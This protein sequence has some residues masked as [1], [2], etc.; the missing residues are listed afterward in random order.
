MGDRVQLSNKKQAYSKGSNYIKTVSAK[1][2]RQREYI[3]AIQDN[4]IVICEGPA[5]TGKTHIATALGVEYLKRNLVKQLII[6]RPVVEAGEDI[7]YLPGDTNQKLDPYV[8]P[9]MN[10]L[11]EYA[12][13]S[14]IAT[15]KNAH[16]IEI[17]PIGYMRGLTFKQS[18]VIIDECQN[19]QMDQMKMILS[20]FGEASKMVISGDTKQ[21]DLDNKQQG[22]L[23]F[24]SSLFSKYPV[25]GI[26]C[27]QL[28]NEDIVRHPVVGKILELW[29][30]HVDIYKI[31]GI[32]E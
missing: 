13:Y 22:G 1:T 30:K 10:E 24:A 32:L 7:G 11:K 12:S 18:F 6:A 16:Q 9:V 26:S 15:W 23:K 19:V 14:E 2:S 8:K 25:D 29:E 27:I 31:K 17:V 5:G 4:D 3:K 28:G 21:S 20:R